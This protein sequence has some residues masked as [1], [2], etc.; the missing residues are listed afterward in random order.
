MIALNEAIKLKGN[1]SDIL[2]HIGECHYRLSQYSLAIQC[3]NSG[4]NSETERKEVYSLRGDAHMRENNFEEAIKDFDSYLQYSPDNPNVIFK[5][6]LVKYCLEQ[7]KEAIVDFSSCLK[8]D[9]QHKDALKYRTDSY[10]A[11]GL[12]DE[13]NQ[14]L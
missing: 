11:L 5:H 8:I 1:F 3:F 9:S 10:K 2:L 6:G 14:D 12:V 4:L 13:V 7:Y